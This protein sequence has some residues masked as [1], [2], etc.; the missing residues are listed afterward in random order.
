LKN[1]LHVPRAS[2]N[3]LSISR[4][5]RDGGC[6]RM[7]QGQITLISREGREFA[8][9]K[10]QKGLYVLNT[11]AKLHPKPKANVAREEIK[12]GWIGWH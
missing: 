7:G 2:N 6:T 5:D 12:D 10:L 3:L 4:L 8:R 1:V 9:A 11:R